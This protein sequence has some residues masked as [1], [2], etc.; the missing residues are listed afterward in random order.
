M[1]RLAVLA[2]VWLVVLVVV[3]S[4]IHRI[5]LWIVL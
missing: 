3:A 2:S 1:L 4:V 5:V